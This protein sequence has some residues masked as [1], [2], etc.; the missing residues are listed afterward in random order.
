M[1]EVEKL[2]GGTGGLEGD[3]ELQVSW[4]ELCLAV[5]LHCGLPQSR[6]SDV[7]VERAGSASQEMRCHDFRLSTGQLV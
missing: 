2:V 6:P 1:A 3:D 4:R 5:T 7:L